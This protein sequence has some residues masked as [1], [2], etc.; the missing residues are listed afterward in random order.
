MLARLGGSPVWDRS[1]VL[2]QLAVAITLET[3]SMRQ[4]ALLAHQ[5]QVFGAPPSDSTIRRALKPIGADEVL[6]NRLPGS[7][8]GPGRGVTGGA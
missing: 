7:G 2:A 3:T 8:S 5:E 1:V 6:A 4:I